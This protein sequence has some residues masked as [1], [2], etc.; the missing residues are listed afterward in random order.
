MLPKGQGLGADRWYTVGRVNYS[1]ADRRITNA[2]VGFE[3]D[4][5]CWLGRVVLER[6]SLSATTANQRIMFQLEFVG[7]S[8]VGTNPLSALR[9]SVPRYQMLRETIPD[10]QSRFSS[11]E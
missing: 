10:N 7:F 1:R 4:A 6:T 11:Y 3:Y 5:G 2:L 9:R 8:R